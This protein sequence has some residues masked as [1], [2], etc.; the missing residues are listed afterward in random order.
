MNEQISPMQRFLL[1]F[2]AFFAVLFNRQFALGVGDLARGVA[3]H[4]IDLCALGDQ[5][6]FEIV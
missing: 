5:L 1:A 3:Q 6:V 2:V 4:A